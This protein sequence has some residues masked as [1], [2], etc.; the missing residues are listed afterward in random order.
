VEALL[1]AAG[2][3]L[4]PVASSHLCCGSAGTYSIL[5]AG[6]SQELRTRKLETLLGGKPESIATANIG[7]LEHLRA[8]SP[9]PVKHWV[10]LVDEAMGG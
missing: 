2:Y 5:Q 7:C 4:T 1:S 3:E 9:V 10:E 6:L 8:A